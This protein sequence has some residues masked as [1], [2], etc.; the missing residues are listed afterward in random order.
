MGQRGIRLFGY[1]VFPVVTLVFAFVLARDRA[2][3]L[4]LLREDGPVEWL[5]VAF[6]A[7][8]GA[9]AVGL[10]W[11]RRRS[12]WRRQW[13]YWALAA[14]CAFGMVEEIS[15]GQRLLGFESPEYFRRHARQEETNVHNL[16][17]RWTT[18]K[19][20]EIAQAVF[21]LGGI[22]APLAARR[23]A[24]LAARLTAWGIRLPP[25]SLWVGILIASLLALDRPVGREE[26]LA[27][28]FMALVLWL[29]MLQEP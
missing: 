7:L 3:Y 20:R 10:G 6:L 12:G 9:W 24:L 17:Q 27:E 22:V 23:F 8:A 18:I 13:F 26:E 4:H 15:W 5:T 14:F 11:A 2:L 16:L 29:W 19:V 25:L 21:L 28:M 1:T